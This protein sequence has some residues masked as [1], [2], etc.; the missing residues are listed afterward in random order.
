MEYRSF[1]NGAKI[2]MLGFGVY[3]IDPAETE[4]AV[5]EALKVGYRHIDTAQAYQNEQGVGDAIAKSDIPR[6]E[7]FI[8]TKIWI[9]NLGEGKTR[10]SLENSL[11]K[12][13]LDY[14]DLV[15]IHQPFGDAYGAWRELEEAQA[16]G[17][18]RNIGVSNFSPVKA[19][20]L[21]YFNAA[22]VAVNQVEV[23]PINQ[24]IKEVELLDEYNIITEAWAP[25]GQGRKGMFTNPGLKVIAEKY[26]KSVAQVILRWLIQRGIVALA[27]TVTPERMAENFDIFDFEI[28]P[29]DMAEI[30][31][32]DENTS[33]FGDNNDPA[34]VAS[35]ASYEV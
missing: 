11:K 8:T 34:K 35:M 33:L 26:N 1:E 31:A 5:S 18:V 12:L 4:R 23:N 32:L 3:Q 6:E 22:P 2:P 20:D 17:L 19:V 28:S 21:S 16:D 15:L 24:R 27:K 14:V 10:K 13:G 25:F 7:L 29:A 30:A 9:N